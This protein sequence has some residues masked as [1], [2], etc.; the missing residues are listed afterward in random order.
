METS[1]SQLSFVKS[2][3]KKVQSG[4]TYLLDFKLVKSTWSQVCV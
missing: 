4:L 3:G 1:S 2:K